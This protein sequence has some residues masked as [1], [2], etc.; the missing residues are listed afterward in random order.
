MGVLSACTQQDVINSGVSS[1]YHDCNMM[2]YMRGDTYNW[3]L[4]VQMIEH[5]GLT[6][7]FEGKVD[8]MPVITFWGNLLPTPSARIHSGSRH[9]TGT[10]PSTTLSPVP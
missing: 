5:A 7:L 4:T 3:E 9:N 8:T 6:D 1:P 2:D 10:P